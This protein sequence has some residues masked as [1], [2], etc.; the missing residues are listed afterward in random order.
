MRS[1][2]ILDGAGGDEVE[3]EHLARLADPV[4]AADALLDRHRVPGNVEVDQRVAELQVAPLAAGFGAQQHRDVV[5]ERVD[6]GVL[7]RAGHIAGELSE[8]RSSWRRSRSA[9]CVRLSR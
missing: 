5:A 4:D 9:R 2:V 8:R 3:D 7:L 6:R 1:T